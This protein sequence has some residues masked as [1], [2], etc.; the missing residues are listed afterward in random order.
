MRPKQD[1]Q[2]QK[3]DSVFACFHFL[4]LPTSLF[5][6]DESYELA[7]PW[8]RLRGKRGMERDMEGRV[9]GSVR[10]KVDV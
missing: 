5:L 9:R 6:P 8:T 7:R 2:Q 4:C 3:S 10:E 1:P